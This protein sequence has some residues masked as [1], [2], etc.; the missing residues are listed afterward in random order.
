[1]IQFYY[2]QII[3]NGD[4]SSYY[5]ITTVIN[6]ISDQNTIIKIFY[7]HKSSSNYTE[8]GSC[9]STY[10]LVQCSSTGIPRLTRFLWQPKNRVRW[11]SCYASLYYDLKKFWKILKNI[12]IALYSISIKSCYENYFLQPQKF[13][14][15][16]FVLWEI[17]LAEGWL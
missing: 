4:K 17:V 2:G 11:N 14:L 6:R 15:C 3:H 12:C 10:F 16:K 1:M 5:L 9:E 13:V 8:T 7:L